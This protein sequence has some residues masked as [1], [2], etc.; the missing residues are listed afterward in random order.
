MAT[1]IGI[2]GATGLVGAQMLEAL[3]SDDWPAEALAVFSGESGAGG[4]LEYAGETLHLKRATPAALQGL[5]VVLLAVPPDAA[6]ALALAAQQ[7]GAWV[8]D[9]SG[10]FRDDLKVPL[11]SPG[12]NDTVLA[13]LPSRLIAL[14][15]A[16]TQTVT[17]VLAPLAQAFGLLEA[18][19]TLL[20]GASSAGGEGLKVLERQTAALLNSRDPEVS[21]FPHRLAFNLVPGVG[22]FE[23]GKSGEERALEHECARVLGPAV[24]FSSTALQVPVFHGVTAVVRARLQREAPEAAVREVLKQGSGLKLLD[25]PAQN[26]YPM[27][28]LAAADDA[29]HVGRLRTLGPHVSLVAAADGTLRTGRLAVTL[30]KALARRE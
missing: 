28:M 8:V 22:A 19:I 26:I 9:C 29:V 2:V 5:K 16:P 23:R 13:G 15:S 18:D 11:V 1:S 12:V 10:A 20:L 7:Q 6:R 24:T 21:V 17:A 3:A 30:A 14:A 25:E 4:E 27:P